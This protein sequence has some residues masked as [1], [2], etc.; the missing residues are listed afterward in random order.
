M[1][2]TIQKALLFSLFLFA[3]QLKA[4]L[5]KTHL[6]HYITAGNSSAAESVY[7]DDRPAFSDPVTLDET[8][9][10]L[11][12]SIFT[13]D[14]G[15][16]NEVILSGAWTD[17]MAMNAIIG[18]QGAPVKFSNE[19]G[20]VLMGTS[21]KDAHG[22]GALNGTNFIELWG[23]DKDTPLKVSANT[24]YSGVQWVPA[25]TSTYGG[26]TFRGYNIHG[27]DVGYAGFLGSIGS[28]GN[29]YK[30]LTL[31]FY[32]LKGDVTEGEHQY[33]GNVSTESP[34]YRLVGLHNSAMNK[35]R[36]G[37]QIK[38]AKQAR[39]YNE[40]YRNVGQVSDVSQQHGFQIEVSKDVQIYDLIVDGA[41]RSVN[42][43][44][45]DVLIK[46]GVIKFASEGYFGDSQDFWPAH[47]NLNGEPV[48]F[49]GV[50]LIYTGAGTAYF[51]EYAEEGANLEFINC[52]FSDNIESSIVDDIRVGGSN[53]IIGTTTTN[54]NS[55]HTVAAL[56]ILTYK[57][58]DI[59]SPDFS[60][61]VN[62][63]YYFNQ[64]FGAG[65]PTKRQI[66]IVDAFEAPDSTAT[67][68]DF[69]D[70]LLLPDSATFLL[71]SGSLTKLPVVWD[72]LD[73]DA[74][75]AA[76]YPFKGYPILPVGIYNTDSVAVDLNIIV[77]E[78]I[79]GTQILINLGGTSTNYVGTGNWNHAP[80]SYSTGAIAIKGDNS[81]DALASLRTSAGDLTGY[82]ISI[83]TQF[84]GNDTR[85]MNSAGAYPA[86]ANRSAWENPG[87]N[88]TSR[89]FTITGLDNGTAYTFKILSS[90]DTFFNC[91]IDVTVAGS[92]GGG[93]AIDDFNG[94]SNVNTVH[95]FAPVYPSSGVVT[96]TVLK[97]SGQAAINVIEINYN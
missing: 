9:T 1:K 81:G 5:N 49:D 51:A 74:E 95:T 91:S 87:G 12:G 32:K 76:T 73:Y 42:I 52:K 59:D 22:I 53:S 50:T 70:S 29:S 83:T 65:T 31:A 56:D 13:A 23:K 37:L 6:F 7:P 44:S 3:G 84:E 18:V 69:F 77:P 61:L 19:D 39:F 68:G 27:E 10:S 57:S 20:T 16:K 94:N 66:E 85:G 79:S 43:F 60:Y 86:N 36:E 80:Q 24:S 82:G 28:S 75:T 47:E 96:I 25:S 41:K 38:W 58:D 62:G 48:V 78:E 34:F 88:G 67:Y 89:V 46:G 45:H 26:S 40:T 17:G 8:E 11:A 55:V 21:T 92:S 71:S 54:G 35:G 97:N 14:L 33:Y 72:S 64:G 15:G 63:S 4:Q 30:K 2:S 93:T 90:L